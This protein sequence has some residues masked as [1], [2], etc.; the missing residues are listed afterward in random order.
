MRNIN[1]III[2]MLKLKHLTALAQKGKFHLE[3]LTNLENSLARIKTRMD[4]IEPYIFVE[5]ED[6]KELN[7]EFTLLK[8]KSI[9]AEKQIEE[10]KQMVVKTGYKLVKLNP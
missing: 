1:L 2:N 9:Q 10:R 6:G 5:T 3:V 7:R 8:S 4:E